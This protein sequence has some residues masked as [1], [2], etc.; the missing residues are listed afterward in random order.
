MGSNKDFWDSM[1]R[2]MRHA[3]YAL[4]TFFA[5]TQAGSILSLLW[6]NRLDLADGTVS[7]GS[8]VLTAHYMLVVVNMVINAGISG[9]FMQ[10]CVDTL[11]KSAANTAGMTAEPAGP[12]TGKANPVLAAA[13]RT[14][15]MRGF[16]INQYLQQCV[17][18]V[19]LSPPFLT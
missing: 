11:T 13:K 5:F 7:A 18:Q 2:R 17:V 6:V 4:C 19:H 12:R 8:H 16:L 10:V 15:N 14:A 9:Y 3:N 1:M